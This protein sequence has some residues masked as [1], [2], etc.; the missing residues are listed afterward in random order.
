MASRS[1][2]QLDQTLDAV[3]GASFTQCSGLMSNLANQI[4]SDSNCGQDLQMQ[5]P[6]VLQAYNGFIAYPT[7]YQAGCLKDDTG[8]YCYANAVMNA[9][10]ASSYYLYYLPLGVQ[11]PGGSVPSCNR[12]LQNTMAIFATAAANSSVPLHMDY[13][14]AAQM[15]DMNCGPSFVDATVHT[16]SAGPAAHLGRPSVA[17]LI[18]LLALPIFLLL[19]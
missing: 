1:L 2:V 19:L 4:M 16:S 3:C 14:A 9:S 10:A 12:C 17:G 13:T 6:L 15:I 11:L 18:G 5:N 8:D 7:L